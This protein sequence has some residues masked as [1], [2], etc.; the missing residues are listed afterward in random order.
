MVTLGFL[1]DD[2]APLAE[3]DRRRGQRD[4]FSR[5]YGSAT[6][7]TTRHQRGL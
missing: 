4:G 7:M 5:P 3:L 1:A 6:L 2:T